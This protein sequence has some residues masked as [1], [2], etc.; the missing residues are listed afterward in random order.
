MYS[1]QTIR[2]PLSICRHDASVWEI[3]ARVESDGK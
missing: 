2:L 1:S 3:T